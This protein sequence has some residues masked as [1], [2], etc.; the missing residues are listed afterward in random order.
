MYN[1]LIN[2]VFFN[3]KMQ[4]DYIRD[5]VDFMRHIYVPEVDP[6]THDIWYDYEDHGHLFKRNVDT[7]RRGCYQAL[8][9]DM[10]QAAYKAGIGNYTENV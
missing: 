9:M 10:L 1:R 2:I 5:G 7:I 3:R 4:N 8:D 6:I